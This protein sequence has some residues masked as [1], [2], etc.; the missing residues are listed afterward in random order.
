MLGLSQCLHR[1]FKRE[2][3]ASTG[4]SNGG[5]GGGGAPPGKGNPVIMGHVTQQ[6]RKNQYKGIY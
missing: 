5:G 1:G 6:A 2:A 3:L 4:S